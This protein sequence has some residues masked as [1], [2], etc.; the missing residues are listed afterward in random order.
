MII[1]GLFLKMSTIFSC[2][3]RVLIIEYME[4]NMSRLL[5]KM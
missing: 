3:Y 4:K 2:K 1:S 5:E